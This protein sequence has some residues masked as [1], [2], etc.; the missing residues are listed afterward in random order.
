MEID[1]L[2]VEGGHSVAVL[3][4]RNDVLKLDHVEML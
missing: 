4:Q 2:Q 1:V 3:Q